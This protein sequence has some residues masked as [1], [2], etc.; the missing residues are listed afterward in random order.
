MVIISEIF[1]LA[2]LQ[3]V[4]MTDGKY[5]DGDYGL[6]TEGIQGR[7]C[8]IDRVHYCQRLVQSSLDLH[9]YFWHEI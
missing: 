2:I 5:P 1:R 9:F 3:E 6:C 8:T 4:C 7:L